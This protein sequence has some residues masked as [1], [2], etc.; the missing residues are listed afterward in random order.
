M[1]SS[2]SVG[3]MASAA[4]TRL[5]SKEKKK[6]KDKEKE[7]AKSSANGDDSDLETITVPMLDSSPGGRKTFKLEINDSVCDSVEDACKSSNKNGAATAEKNSKNILKGEAKV[8]SPP[9]PAVP[10]GVKITLPSPCDEDT[11]VLNLQP[12]LNKPFVEPTINEG[13]ELISIDEGTAMHNPVQQVENLSR[14]PPPLP[15]RGGGKKS[16][17][18]NVIASPTKLTFAPSTSLHT[19]PNNTSAVTPRLSVHDTSGTFGGGGG[20]ATP[21]RLSVALAAASLSE[22]RNLNYV[23]LK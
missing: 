6:Q 22:G 11:P 12:S 16:G 3:Q 13:S 7:L 10:P 20:G 18:N 4:L 9:L 21:R 14:K 1:T 5:G 2:T 8:I 17:E 23:Y 19:Y 15:P